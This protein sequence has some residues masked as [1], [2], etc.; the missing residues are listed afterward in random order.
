MSRAAGAGRC[1]IAHVWV[2]NNRLKRSPK[3]TAE[4]L[5]GLAVAVGFTAPRRSSLHA[6]TDAGRTIKVHDRC[7][8]SLYGATRFEHGFQE[9]SGRRTAKAS[10]EAP[11]AHHLLL[12]VF[13]EGELDM[14]IET[15]AG[16]TQAWITPL[17]AIGGYMLRRYCPPTSNSA[18]V[19]CPSEQQ[20]TA[21]ISTSNTLR[22]S[23][24]AC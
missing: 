22:L 8:P 24:T 5:R 23:M 19:I 16:N 6:F 18:F 17:R 15:F 21:S 10:A 14:A 20:R 12:R 1:E 2:S 9:L 4:A 11:N 13:L 7:L 3:E